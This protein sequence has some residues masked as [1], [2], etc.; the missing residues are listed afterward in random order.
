V[1]NDFLTLPQRAQPGALRDLTALAMAVAPSG[2]LY[3]A[4]AAVLSRNSDGSVGAAVVLR[5]STDHG[6]TWSVPEFV[7]DAGAGDRFMPAISVLADGSVGVAFYDRRAGLNELDTYA[8]RASFVHG[9]EVSPNVRVNARPSPATD[10]LN[11][12]KGNFCLPAG[13][14]FGDYIGAASDGDELGVVWT[15]TQRQATSETDAWF[16]RVSF[17][18]MAAAAPPSSGRGSI[19]SWFTGLAGHLH[20]SGGQLIAVG[21]FL[22]LPAMTAAI[23]IIAL[24]KTDE[25]T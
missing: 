3:I 9:F 2:A 15:D 1:G 21:I 17:P 10:V 18:P 7:N 16:A 19:F 4:Y 22:L 14:F 11:V 25:P 12:K 6:A 5:R 20:L 23:G 8:A 24:T 13:R